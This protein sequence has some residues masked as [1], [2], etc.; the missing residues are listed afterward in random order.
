MNDVVS[1]YRMF[2]GCHLPSLRACCPHNVVKAHALGGLVYVGTQPRTQL[3]ALPPSPIQST[4]I[5]DLN[6][7]SRLVS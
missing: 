3:P 7:S 2:A 1:A 6:E 4:S 5:R